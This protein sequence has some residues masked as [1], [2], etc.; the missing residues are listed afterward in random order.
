M[1]TK[2]SLVAILIAMLGCLGLVITSWIWFINAEE[3]VALMT[4]VGY[5]IMLILGASGVLGCLS[6]VYNEITGKDAWWWFN[7]EGL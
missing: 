3:N 7:D 4:V 6:E 1:R 5:F 2:R